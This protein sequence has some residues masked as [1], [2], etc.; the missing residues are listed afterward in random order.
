MELASDGEGLQY[1]PSRFVM[2]IITKKG[3]AYSPKTLHHLVCG[4]MRHIRQNCDQLE[5]DP[6]FAD[7]H[8]SL[9][10]MKQLQAAG[11]G[12]IKKQAEPLTLE[13]EELLWEKKLLC[14]YSPE[15][16]LNT[17]V[18]MNGLYFA[19]RSGNK[20]HQL[21]HNPCQIQVI[22]NPGE[23]PYLQY[24]EDS[25]KNHPGGLKG[26]KQKPKVVIHHSNEENPCLLCFVRR[27]KLYNSLCPAERPD[28]AFYLAP[29]TKPKEQCWFSRTPLGHNTLKNIVKRMCETAGIPS[30][31]T[32]HS[33]RVT[34]ATS[35]YSK[36]IDEQMVM[37]RAG[38]RSI[39]GY[40]RT[41]SE[42]QENISDI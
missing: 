18:F 10:E 37:E 36:G 13:E 5:I 31:I 17:M 20:H 35:L 42:Q 23:R 2:E 27:F 22:E 26:H 38:H 14:N 1:W 9:A 30:Y 29:L 15:G 39:E 32:N 40:K 34:T 11:V 25:F 33:L 12:S 16:L 41:S 21:R 24:T 8:S 3:T 28:N 4:I 19:L 6:Q 7:F